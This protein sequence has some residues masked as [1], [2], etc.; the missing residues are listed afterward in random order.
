MTNLAAGGSGLFNTVVELVNVGFAG[1]GVV[2]LLFVFIILMQSKPADTGTQHLRQRFLTLGMAFAFF[3]GVLSVAAPLLAPR[4]I[5]SKPADM[6]LS[7]SPR[8]ESEGLPAPNITLPDGE[9]IQ[10]GKTFAAQGGQVLVSVDDALK[11]IATLKQTALTLADT[12][13]A[14]QKQADAAVAALAEA[15]D[16]AAP[17]P[18]AAAKEQAEA[19]SQQSQQA[20][21]AISTA[22]RAG[23]FKV[24]ETQNRTLGTTSRASIAARNRAITGF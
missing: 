14:A 9:M 17:A 20:S 13:G 15:K 23:D 3:C 16:G 22:I 21:A 12:A 19:A 10:P 4:P 18:A 6:L 8:F 1:V 5:S 7:F 2:V 24:L 11:S